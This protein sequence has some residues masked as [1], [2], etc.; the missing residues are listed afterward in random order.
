[1]PMGAKHFADEIQRRMAATDGWNL[2][3]VR[4]VRREFSRRLA[5]S[6]GPLMVEIA[7]KLVGKA[8]LFDRLLAYE[9]ITFHPAALMSL[10]SRS[11]EALGRGMDNWATV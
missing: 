3:R 11:V 7:L 6:D 10:N 8:G 9:L 4:E 5:S 2:V 1:R